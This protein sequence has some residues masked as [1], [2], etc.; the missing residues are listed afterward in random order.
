[1]TARIRRAC[2]MLRGVGKVKVVKEKDAAA[3][4]TKT[5][6]Y[7]EAMADVKAGRVYKAASSEDMFAQI[8]DD[9]QH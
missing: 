7:R 3:D 2:G 6:G 9:V 5:R 1:M 4:V 8:L